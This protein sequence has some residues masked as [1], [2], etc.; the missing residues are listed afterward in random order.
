MEF[1]LSSCWFSNLYLS[2]VSFRCGSSSGPFHSISN[3]VSRRWKGKILSILVSLLI[4]LSYFAKS[5]KMDLLNRVLLRVS[6]PLF[7]FFIFF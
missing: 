2:C 5:E 1:F 4:L 6:S 3:M 7:L